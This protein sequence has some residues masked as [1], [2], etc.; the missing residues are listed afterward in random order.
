VEKVVDDVI[1]RH[2]RLRKGRGKKVFQVQ[3]RADWNKGRA[4]QWLLER[5]DLDR[6]DV[7][8]I[9]IGDDLTDEDAFRTL[10]GRGVGIAVGDEDRATAA[11]YRLA[12]SDDTERFLGLLI[13]LI[14][15]KNK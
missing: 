15:G 9:Y 14:N 6:E 8:P 3:P 11:D 12:S 13:S 7:L 1:A 5:L 10:A 4:V 2:P